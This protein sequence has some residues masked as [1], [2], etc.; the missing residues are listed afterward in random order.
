MAAVDSSTAGRSHPR[1][2][3]LDVSADTRSSGALSH[4]TTPAA[5]ARRPRALCG[6]ARRCGE[7]QRRRA[8]ITSAFRRAPG[9][10]RSRG[11][12]VRQASQ[13]RDSR[14]LTPRR[15]FAGALRCSRRRPLRTGRRLLLARAGAL[16]AAGHFTQKGHDALQEAV[17]IVPDNSSALC[18]TVATTC[19]AIER[20]L[21]RYEQA[22]ERLVRGSSRPRS[23]PRSSPSAADRADAQRVLPL[24]I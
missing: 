24:A 14:P 10:R 21:G 1:P 22:H 12:L 5:G 16:S 4:E 8:P 7:R 2:T 17:A 19:A 9:R 11:R 3:C 13:Q 23:R 20:Q 15:W 6:S 18:T